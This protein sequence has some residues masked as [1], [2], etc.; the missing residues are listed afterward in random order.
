M[1]ATPLTPRAEA[2]HTAALKL[3]SSKIGTA[4]E[5]RNET[6]RQAFAAGMS[7]RKIAEIVGMTRA[8]IYQIVNNP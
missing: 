6:I 2:K 3:A 7:A 8:R 1:S 5:D 4:Q